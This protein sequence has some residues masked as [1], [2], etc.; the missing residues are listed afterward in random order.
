MIKD[1][2]KVET[3]FS[4]L[5]EVQESDLHEVMLL[6]NN[7]KINHLN[8][9]SNK[10]QDQVE[11]FQNYKIRQETDGEIY[12]KIFDKEFKNKICGLVRITKLFNKDF[13]SWES[14]I[15]K[16]G[17]NPIIAYDVAIAI[18]T[19]GFDFFN[20]KQCGPWNVPIKATNVLNFHKNIDMAKILD[21]NEIYY[22]MKI[23]YRDFD[24]RKKFFYQK[25][26]GLILNG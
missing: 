20:K 9:I 8:K 3:N 13:F 12:Y 21:I 5:L 11:Y 4:Y 22:I 2:L 1:F 10:I 19:I 14:F 18:F 26:I 16:D 23:N 6:R 17:S 24:K 15:L 25:K 7:R